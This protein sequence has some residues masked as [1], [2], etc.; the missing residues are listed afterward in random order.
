MKSSGK[1]TLLTIDGK[2][3]LVHRQQQL[4][5]KSLLDESRSNRKYTRIV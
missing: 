5:D 1:K 4:V 2:Q 3:F